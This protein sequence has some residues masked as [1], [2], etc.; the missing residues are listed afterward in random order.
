MS[1][2]DLNMRRTVFSAAPLLMLIVVAACARGEAETSTGEVAA[3]P[4][5]VA[6]VVT[7][8][9]TLPI[10]S[11]GTLGADEELTLGFKVGGVIATVAASPGDRVRAGQTLARLDTREIDA[12]VARAEAAAEKA[13]RDADRARR[14]FAGGVIPQV[15]MQDAETAERVASADLTTARFNRRFAA[16][17]MPAAG[18]VLERAKEP[19]E[20][21]A[22][23]EPVL[24]V[25]TGTRGHVLR[26][27]LADR[28]VVRVRRGSAARV[29]FDAF[30]GEHF[31]GRVTEIGGAANDRTG[32]YMVEISLL[33]DPR[34]VSGLI[35]TAEIESA[36]GGRHALV[37]VDALL[38]V[39][40]DA[41]IVFTLAP[42]GRTVERRQVRVGRV[43]GERVAIADGLENGGTVITDGVAYL[44][45]GA[46]VEVVP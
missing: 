34:L 30:P 41:G 1:S 18:V 43:V 24:V 35:G 23:G 9:V 40:G 3:I 4:V 28:D 10:L 19:G 16:I 46:Q 20:L 36:S 32:T 11:T 38:E 44:R 45:D 29:R 17:V 6:E 5:R 12:A 22:A 7:D 14:L 37:P 27:G 26:V 8:T 25:A 2:E 15:Q 31:D 39:D 33:S 13:T 21:V 42:D